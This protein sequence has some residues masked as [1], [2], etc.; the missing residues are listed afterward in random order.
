MSSSGTEEDKETRSGI[1]DDKPKSKVDDQD[2]KEKSDIK[3]GIKSDVKPDVKTSVDSKTGDDLEAKSTTDDDEK[4]KDDD[5]DKSS[6]SGKKSEVES[7]GVST[8]KME[9]RQT[10]VVETRTTETRN[11]GV[12]T[13]K[14]GI[15]I[16]K[17]G[18]EIRKSGVEA[19]KS[20]GEVRKS[21][22]EA[23]KS[24]DVRKSGVESRKSETTKSGSKSRKNEARKSGVET[25]KSGEKIV[26]A[27]SETGKT[28]TETRKS[29]KDG[30]QSTVEARKSGV[31]SRKSG[32][33]GRKSGVDDRQSGVE[34]RKSGMDGRQSTSEARK[35]GVDVRKSTTDARKSRVDD[36]QTGADARKSGVEEGRQYGAEARKSGVDVRKSGTEVR[37]S[38][39]DVRKGE[40]ENGV[41]ILQSEANLKTC[42]K[43]GVHVAHSTCSGQKRTK[44]SMSGK[45]RTK[46]AELNECRIGLIG[47]GRMAESM[48]RGLIRSNRVNGKQ[49][50]VAAKTT[51]NLDTFK[52]QGASVSTRTYDIF[53]RF[54]CDIVFL[55]VHG[56]VVRNC[57]KLGGTRPAPFTTNYIPTRRRPIFILSMIGGVPLSDVRTTLLNPETGHKYKVE[58]NRLVLNASICYGIGLGALDVELDSKK[59]HPLVRDSLQAI[60]KIEC[61]S[62][63]V[64]DAV[65]AMIGS[66]IAFVYYFISALADGGFKMGLTKQTATKLATKTIKCASQCLLESNKNPIDLRDQ[67]TSPSGPAIYGLAVLDK[68]D[69]ASGVQIAIESAYRRIK[70]LTEASPDQIV[71]T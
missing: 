50:Y 33:E 69:C 17:S 23:R 15:E 38:A 67:C 19:R 60:A 48:M 6:K 27:V 30:R 25:R 58:L 59:C 1:Q 26:T 45:S 64:M 66:G 37:G 16:R 14:S 18:V 35:S 49:F 39:V 3:S 10:V 7:N 54:D 71:K 70:E 52:V 22:V 2:D 31:D 42:C 55:C 32:T 8:S 20:G 46:V 9:T 44:S 41:E 36:R 47:S 65:C 12:E 61:V 34:A 29:G 43:S 40:G 56:F 51:K 5:K 28:E 62:A 11:N 53:G 68:Q 13:R 57:F 24:G 63:E 21:T 4:N